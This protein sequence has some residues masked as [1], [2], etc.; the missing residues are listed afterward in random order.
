MEHRIALDAMGGDDA[1]AAVIGGALAACS[2][3]PNATSVDVEPLQPSTILLVG[4]PAAIEA[5]LAARGGN[6]GFEIVPATQVIG[7]DESPAQALRAK[8]DSSIAVAVGA[9]KRGRASAFVSMGNTGACVG[10]ATLGLGTLEGVH[11]PGIF[12]TLDL[13]GQPLTFADMGANVAP[14]PEHL[15]QYGF[16]GSVYAASCLGQAKPRVGLLNIGEESSK[17]T[18]FAKKAH[19]LL[20]ASKLDF[21]GNVEGNHLFEQPVDVVVTDGFTGNVALK[22]MEGLATHL[23]RMFGKEL[24]RRG[25]EWANEVIGSIRRRVDYSEYGGALL[26]GVAGTVVVGHGRSDARAV[27]NALHVAARAMR[28]GVNDQIVEGL[29]RVTA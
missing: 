6:P 17:G 27:G 26:L 29:A 3:D 9:V 12:V 28:A 19:E 10:A 25:A 24:G 5:E 13:T 18:D 21:R 1:P 23:L 11:R 22:L 8:P 7:M 14:K 20:A 4:D 16:M 15:V 2:A